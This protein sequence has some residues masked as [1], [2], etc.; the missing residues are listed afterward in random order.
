MKMRNTLCLLVALATLTFCQ[1]TAAVNIADYGAIPNDGYSDDAALTAA[2]SDAG[3]MDMIEAPAGEFHFSSTFIASNRRLLFTGAGAKSTVFTYTGSGCLFDLRKTGNTEAGFYQFTNL[4]IN[5][6]TAGATCAIRVGS[7]SSSDSVLGGVDS[8]HVN[9]VVIES[10]GS[11]YWLYGIRTVDVGGVYVSNT[12]IRNNGSTTAQNN[13]N[14][15]GIYILNNSGSKSVIRALYATNFYVQRF[16]RGVQAH[17]VKSVEG[18]YLNGG[19]VVGTRNALQTTGAG[20]VGAIDVQGGHYDCLGSCVRFDTN[21][22]ITR[23]TN[24]DMR[25]TSNGGSPTSEP[26]IDINANA[27]TLLV[28]NSHLEANGGDGVQGGH[29]VVRA[30]ITGLVVRDA[31][32]A[33]DIPGATALGVICDS[34]SGSVLDI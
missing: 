7:N 9:N 16:Y 22:N 5:T 13:S 14:T 3:A 8:L 34:C 33:V 1:L 30:V 12:T 2:L 28:S 15:K 19:S 4:T 18:I 26:V 23:I 25:L 21:T 29:G 24:V 6:P 10:E 32:N 11:G 27:D 17:A 20:K 31:Q